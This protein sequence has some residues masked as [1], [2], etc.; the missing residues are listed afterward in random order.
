MEKY[1]GR[2]IAIFTDIHGL[3]EPTV[4]VLED[5]KKRG[6][7]EIYCLGDSIEIGPNPGEVLDLL[8]EYGVVSING[9]S[10]E[11]SILG[12]EPFIGYFDRNKI[13]NQEWT[14]SKLTREQLNNLKNNK[15]SIDLLVGGKKIGLCHFANDVRIDFDVRSTWSYQ[16]SINYGL[17]NPQRQFYYTNSPAQERVIESHGNSTNPSDAGF[18]S[19][20]N[21]RLFGGKTVDYYDEIIEGHV[22]FRLLTE[23]EKVKI[24]T[25]RAL[26]MAYKGNDQV[27]LASYIIIREKEVGYDVEEIL[28]PFDR[29][30][31]LQSIANSDMP[32]KNSAYNFTSKLK[33]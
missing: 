20:K 7:T 6:I 1:T 23:D 4:A 17:K 18:V 14:K 12:I 2:E 27:D 16:D 26:A 9:N 29:S 31:M 5:I 24:R 28:V 19:A 25:L 10:E 22:H 11:Y 8:S 32:Y 13:L 30:K 21:D 3:L 15:H 33:R